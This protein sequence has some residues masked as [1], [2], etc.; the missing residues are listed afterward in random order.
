MAGPNPTQVEA[1]HELPMNNN[2]HIY[3][4]KNKPH[5]VLY[6]KI[7]PHPS[8]VGAD[9]DKLVNNKS[10]TEVIHTIRKDN[11]STPPF[12]VRISIICTYSLQYL[13]GVITCHASPCEASILQAYLAIM[14]I[15]GQMY[16]YS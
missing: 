1:N 15:K 10:A 5:K 4:P 9:R 13:L 3:L 14:Q 2:L 12:S 8:Q 16:I 6:I 11:H 7:G